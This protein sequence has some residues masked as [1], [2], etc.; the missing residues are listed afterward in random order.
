MYEQ[1]KT[2]CITDSIFTKLKSLNEKGVLLKDN[3]SFLKQFED[4]QKVIG[5]NSNRID[6][7]KMVQ[8]M[9]KCE[10]QGLIDSIN[11]I[12]VCFENGNFQDYLKILSNLLKY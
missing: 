7:I 10:N 2:N 3:S 6:S 8:N 12:F 1:L 11:F 9:V 5:E 4:L